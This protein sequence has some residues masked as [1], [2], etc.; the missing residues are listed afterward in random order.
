[1]ARLDLGKVVGKDGVVVNNLFDNSNFKTNQRGKTTYTGGNQYTVD[2]WKVIKNGTVNVIEDGITFTPNEEGGVTYFNQSIEHERLKIGTNYTMAIRADG[3]IAC[4]SFIYNGETSGSVVLYKNVSTKLQMA[5]YYY[6]SYVACRI[7]STAV[8][9]TY[10]INWAALYE[11]EYT[12]ETLPPYVPKDYA[13]ELVKCRLYY[14]PEQLFFAYSYL[15]A[16]ITGFT[17]EPMRI[18]QP[19]ITAKISIITDY[20]PLE[21]ETTITYKGRNSVGRLNNPNVVKGGYYRVLAEF[22]ADL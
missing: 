16:A 14:R 4:G 19:T 12:A 1:M 3:E 7:L 22:N 6:D 9:T 8:G 21:G 5:I 10:T 17:F 20:T 13:A 15:N 18:A 11:G 2:R